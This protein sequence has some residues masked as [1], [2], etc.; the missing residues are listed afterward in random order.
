M[1]N[2]KNIEFMPAEIKNFS[3]SGT[4]IQHVSGYASVFGN[5]D[6]H[7]DVILR[8]AFEGTIERFNERKINLY[9]SHSMDARDLLGT[10]TMMREDDIGLY[11]E[12][13]ISQSQSAQ[14]IAL[15]A[16]E[17][18]LDE[19]SIGFFTLD[20]EIRED[21]LRLIKEIEL[22]EISLV[23]RASNS[24]AKILEVRQEDIEVDPTH[25]IPKSIVCKQE[26]EMEEENKN[27]EIKA[28]E[29]KAEIKETNNIEELK[30][31]QEEIKS[32]KEAFNKPVRKT[33][34]ETGEKVVEEKKTEI[35]QEK[36]E[37]YAL[38][39]LMSGKIDKFA[40]HKEAGLEEKALQSNIDG[41]GGVLVPTVLANRIKQERARINRIQSRVEV[42]NINGPFELPDFEF[43]ETHGAHAETGAI[44]VDDISN[45]FGKTRLD[46]Q[47]F[48][49]IVLVSNRLMRRNQ[50]EPLES[51][52]AVRYSR[53]HA[54]QLEDHIF[55]GTGHNEPLGIIQ[56]I[57][58][59]ETAGDKTVTTTASATLANVD[60]DSLV[61]L[62]MLLDEEY[63]QNAVFFVSPKMMT[64]IKKLKD[65]G[66][67]PIW[68]RPVSAGQ[69][70]TLLG[71]P[72]FESKS[73]DNSS[74]GSAGKTVAVFCD[75]KE[76]LL[77]VEENFKIDVLRELYQ[78]ND[79]IGLKMMSAYDGCPL[80]KKAFGRI[81]TA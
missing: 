74:L 27:E 6:S 29:V 38:Q 73:L 4:G 79:R 45:A 71:Y 59:T 64:A 75:P 54:D 51:F 61:D 57:D 67:M 50:V 1:T 31:L 3:Q 47:D 44:A 5:I 43:S 24:Q 11:F 78:A 80:D 56:F 32:L 30:A 37:M 10:V 26:K 65:T 66:N 7:G 48:A 8:G 23:S 60:Y 63:R 36:K 14:D 39:D 9:S 12:A 81:E 18:H 2:K 35:S 46:P 77:G 21:G 76:Y 68:Q 49:T 13:T 55:S 69:P 72:I 70:A 34:H 20:E 53:K 16:Q 25:V 22:V 33:A 40:Y 15:K 17:G 58:T 52:L 28:E 42:L 62:E 19:I 41:S